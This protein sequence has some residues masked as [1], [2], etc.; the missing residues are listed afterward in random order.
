MTYAPKIDAVQDG[1]C[2]QTIRSMRKRKITVGD[3]ILFHGWTDPKKPY[4]SKWN[5]RMRVTVTDVIYC[6]ASDGGVKFEN[7]NVIPWDDI[8]IDIIAMNDFIDP[9]TGP[10]LRDVLF[11][12]NGAPSTPEK[13]QVIR[14]RVDWDATIELRNA[15]NRIKL[16]EVSK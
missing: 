8:I 12:L 5:N 4:N 14:W 6:F 9:P 7:T 15:Q 13:Y 1:R 16:I 10:A 3:S 11:E 2:T